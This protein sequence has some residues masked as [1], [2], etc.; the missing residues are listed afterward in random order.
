MLHCILII[1]LVS[2]L[3]GIGVLKPLCDLLAVQDTKVLFVTL[4]GLENILKVGKESVSRNRPNAENP[5]ISQIE[6]IEG[7]YHIISANIKSTQ[8]IVA[9]HNHSI[10]LSCRTT[11]YI[12]SI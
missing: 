10:L 9:A 5:Y 8:P 7:L 11:T 2:Y 4:Q 12:D 1:I 3:V 6:Q